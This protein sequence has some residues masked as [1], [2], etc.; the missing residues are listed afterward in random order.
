MGWSSVEKSYKDNF[1][2]LKEITI[3]YLAKISIKGGG[4]IKAFSA[5]REF[6]KFTFS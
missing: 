5:T 6:I 3:L 4:T 1:K 2:I